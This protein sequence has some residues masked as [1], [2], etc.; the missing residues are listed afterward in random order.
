M[1]ISSIPSAVSD[2]IK[3]VDGFATTIKDAEESFKSLKTKLTSIHDRRDS[4]RKH[5]EEDQDS[6]ALRSAVNYKASADSRGD[7]KTA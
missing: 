3:A 6:P 7:S 1:D 4:L 5:V 2:I